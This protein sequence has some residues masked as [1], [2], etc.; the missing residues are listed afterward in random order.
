VALG[1]SSSRDSNNS[2]N[3]EELFE[4]PDFIGAYHNIHNL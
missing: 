4:S 3:L 1:S 2:S